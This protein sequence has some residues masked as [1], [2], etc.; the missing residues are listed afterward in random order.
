MP[1]LMRQ[2]KEGEILLKQEQ[3]NPAYYSQHERFQ[4][5][6]FRMSTQKK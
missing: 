6:T 3:N 5:C 2:M 1:M 4:H